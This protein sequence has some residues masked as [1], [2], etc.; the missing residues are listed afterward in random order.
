[1]S[2]KVSYYENLILST[3]RGYNK[4][5]ASNAKPLYLLA[6][7]KGIE[8]GILLGNKIIFDE[9]IST[10]YIEACQLFEPWRIPAKFYKP[11]FHLNSEPYYYIKWKNGVKIVNAL[12]TP[13]AKFLRENVE[14]ACLDD[15]LWE[16][17]Q[18]QDTRNELREAIIQH[19]I[20]PI[21]RQ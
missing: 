18:D 1:M 11:Y 6:I 8:E 16:L 14:Y 20:K 17:L 5:I 3:N 15:E 21:K 9:I 4:G 12:Q 7:F 19:F 13:S 10:L 2:L